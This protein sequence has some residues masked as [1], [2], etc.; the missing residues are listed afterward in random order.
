M[1]KR[2]ALE[3]QD[4]EFAENAKSHNTWESQLT[5]F[6]CDSLMAYRRD[7]PKMAYSL[8]QNGNTGHA[9]HATATCFHTLIRNAG[10]IWSD[11]LAEGKGHCEGWVAWLVSR[12]L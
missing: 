12:F 7:W 5:K 3:E 9:M 1:V 4:L 2:R 8:N 6:E 11:V 10:I